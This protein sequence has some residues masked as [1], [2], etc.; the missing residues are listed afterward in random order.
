MKRAAIVVSTMAQELAEL[1]GDIA[2]R[3]NDEEDQGM[4]L[5]HAMYWAEKAGEADPE[6]IAYLDE[7]DKASPEMEYSW[8]EA[9]EI[10]IAEAMCE[11]YQERTGLL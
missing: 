5:R 2:E 3:R 1:L 10:E 9:T 6:K 11:T 4:Y 7:L 8:R